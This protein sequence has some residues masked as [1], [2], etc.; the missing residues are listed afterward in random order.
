MY[1]CLCSAFLLQKRFLWF[2]EKKNENFFL[3]DKCWRSIWNRFLHDTTYYGSN[4]M[5]PVPTNQFVVINS[6]R[7]TIS[8][9][10]RA[11]YSLSAT[12]LRMSYPLIYSSF[13]HFSRKIVG[14]FIVFFGTGRLRKWRLT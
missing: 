10:S 13:C 9:I 2:H 7:G 5:I 1:Y 14:E 12:L 11:H 8:A 4:K 3:P 6:L